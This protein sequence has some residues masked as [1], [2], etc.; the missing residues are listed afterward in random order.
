MEDS[1]FHALI[2]HSRDAI[3]L[4]T[5]AGAIVYGSPPASACRLA[6]RRA[7][8][9]PCGGGRTARQS[10][11][12]AAGARIDDEEGAIVI[13]RHDI[14]ERRVAEQLLRQSEQRFRAR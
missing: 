9:P 2:E 4:L 11:R 8:R 5:A 6:R 3:W 7:A 10:R 1:A 13:S 12:N 14:T